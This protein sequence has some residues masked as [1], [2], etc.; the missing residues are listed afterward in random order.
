VDSRVGLVVYFFSGLASI[1]R[2]NACI[3][4]CIEHRWMRKI[5]NVW[6]ITKLDHVKLIKKQ[7]V[8]A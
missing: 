3:P 1:R 8:M 2:L 5:K 6:K 4:P 7:G